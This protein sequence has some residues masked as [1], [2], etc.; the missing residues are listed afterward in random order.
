MATM[1]SSKAE[2]VTTVKTAEKVATVKSVVESVAVEKATAKTAKTIFAKQA[3]RNALL[4]GIS[5]RGSVG[6]A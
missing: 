6:A 3:E 2:K 1:K 5:P 4:R